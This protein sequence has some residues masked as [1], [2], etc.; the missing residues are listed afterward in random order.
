MIPTSS[1]TPTSIASIKRDLK[2]YW[3]SPFSKKQNIT[4]AIKAFSKLSLLITKSMSSPLTS[5][6][7]ACQSSYKTPK[8]NTYSFAKAQ[9]KKYSP[10]APKPKSPTETLSL[11]LSKYVTKLNKSHSPTTKMDSAYSSSPT[12]NCPQY[13]PLIQK[14]MN[15]T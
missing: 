14:M 2:I 15:Q 5:F 13:K 1:N 9:K 12:K 10:S 11:S 6:E 8:A 3:T 4:T 7:D